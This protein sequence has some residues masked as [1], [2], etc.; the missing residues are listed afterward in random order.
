M[1]A[2][3]A[4]DCTTNVKV[5]KVVNRIQTKCFHVGCSSHCFNLCINDILFPYKGLKTKVNKLMHKLKNL[6]RTAKIRCFNSIKPIISS[7]TRLNSVQDMLCDHQKLSDFMTKLDDHDII[8]LLPNNRETKSIE[9]L[10]IN[11]RNWTKSPS[12]FKL[13]T[14]LLQMC[15]LSWMMYY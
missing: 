8:E 15:D 4:D 11:Y 1:G 14:H 9:D 7:V 5:A 13:K 12:V 2:I 3:T 10:C 6:I